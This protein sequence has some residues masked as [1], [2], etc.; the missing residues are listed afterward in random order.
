MPVSNRLTPHSSRLIAVKIGLL[1]AGEF[2]RGTLLPAMKKVKGIEF[3]GVCTASGISAQHVAHK[4]DFGYATT[5]E[6]QILNDPKINTVV[7]ATRHHL[8]ARQVIA[9]LKAGKHVFVEKPLCIN[10]AELKKIIDVYHSTLS[11]RPSGLVLMVGYNRRFSP[12]ALRLKEFLSDIHEPLVMHYRVNAG[13][14]PHNHWVHDSEQGGGRIIGEVCHFVDFLTFLSGSLPSK[15]YSKALSNNGRYQ[16][17]NLTATI[18]FANGSLGN[19]TYVANGNKG[20]P[21]ERVEV[22]GGEKAA[23][24]D[25]FK[26]LAMVSNQ[27]RRTVRSRFK[28][29]K[30]HEAEWRKFSEKMCSEERSPIP[31]DENVEVARGT[32]AI[33]KSIKDFDPVVIK[34]V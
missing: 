11:T 16:N 10:E 8:H 28:Q 6:S 34:G 24:L 3:V 5:D 1:G 12:M 4:F 22:F 29:D 32:F 30:G 27:K 19:I 17:D 18:E 25:N 13:Y 23:V 33:A 9:A 21:K 26:E 15:V 14:I 2:A 7:I 20:F 31:F